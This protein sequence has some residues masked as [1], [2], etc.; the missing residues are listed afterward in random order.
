MFYPLNVPDLV[1]RNLNGAFANDPTIPHSPSRTRR[2]AGT[3]Q[4]IARRPDRDTQLS[5]ARAAIA[6]DGCG[7]RTD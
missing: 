3:L 4:S 6:T 5:R 7:A 1:H 2:L